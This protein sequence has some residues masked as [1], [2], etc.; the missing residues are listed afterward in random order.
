MANSAKC[1]K[2]GEECRVIKNGFHHRWEMNGLTY[3]GDLWGCFGC[4]HFQLHG[5]PERSHLWEPLIGMVYGNRVTD[6]KNKRH[7]AI[8][9]PVLTV[10][11]EF[12]HY[13]KTWYPHWGHAI[14][15]TKET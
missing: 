3:T 9:D 15:P 13:M 12:E 10:T 11:P 6:P 2:C 8:L 4:G 1:T 14:P 5:I 7:L